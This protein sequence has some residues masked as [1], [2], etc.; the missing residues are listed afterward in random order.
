MARNGDG[1]VASY[2]GGGYKSDIRP[3]QATGRLKRP[4]LFSFDGPPYAVARLPW[5]RSIATAEPANRLLVA[6]TVEL[7]PASFAVPSPF[8]RFPII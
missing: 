5:W 2:I 8:T 7:R 6:V 4:L 1:A 3:I